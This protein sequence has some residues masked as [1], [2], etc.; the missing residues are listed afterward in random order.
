MTRFTLAA[1]ALLAVVFLSACR[2]SP[3]R[4]V[5]LE[6]IQKP[7]PPKVQ[8][9]YDAEVAIETGR[10]YEQPYRPLP[11]GAALTYD[12]KTDCTVERLADHPADTMPTLDRWSDGIA[13]YQVHCEPRR[14]Q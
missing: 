6:C 14:A 9:D 8:A 4:L 7:E 3:P 13:V 12:T 10:I 1:V 11:G 5:Q 2:H